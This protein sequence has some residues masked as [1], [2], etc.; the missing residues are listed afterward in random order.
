MSNTISK[1]FVTFAF[2]LLFALSTA[3]ALTVTGS[4][5]YDLCQCET[6]KQ[7]YTVCADTTGTYGVSVTGIAS[8]WIS[9]APQSLNISAGQC[10]TFYL[11]LTPECYATADLYPVDLIITG[12]EQRTVSI[13]VNVEQC[14]TFDYTIVPTTNTSKPCE[15]N[16]YNL[17]VRN[18]GKFVD[19]F[20]LLEN[21]LDDSWINYPRERFVLKAGEEL[22]SKVVVKSACSAKEGNYPFSMTLSNV[23]TNASRSINLTQI[24]TGFTPVETTFTGKQVE[25]NSCSEA[26]KEYNLYIKNVSPVA[27]EYTL[28]ITDPSILSLNKTS[29][30][31][32]SGEVAELKLIIKSA[33][34]QTLYPTL[35]ITSK[36]YAADY[37]QSFKLSIEDCQNIYLERVTTSTQSCFE[38]T[39]HL[40]RLRNNGSE[41][42]TAKISVSGIE[43]VGA[44][45]V[46]ESGKFKDFYLNF[47]SKTIGVK[48]VTV[49]A[50]TQY[51][52]SK[53][54]FNFEVMN[55]YDIQV[56]VPKIK[57]CPGA[58]IRDK[59]VF[60]NEGVRDQTININIDTAPW[61]V[62]DSAKV[63]VPA[64]EEVEVYFTANI[65]SV[66]D[67]MYFLRLISYSP[68]LDNDIVKA[69]LR[70][71]DISTNMYFELNDRDACYAYEAIYTSS[72]LDINCCQGKI[73]DL[74]ITNLG[75]FTQRIDL[76]RIAPEWV[77]FSDVN[78][79]IPQ[80][81]TKVVYIYFHPPAG[82]NGKII[83]TIELTNQIGTKKT[84][85]YDLNV[86]GGNCGLAYR[87]DLNVENTIGNTTEFTRKEVVV[88]FLVSNDSN[89][90]FAVNNI[91]VQDYNS[92]VEFEEGVFLQPGESTTAKLTVM[93]PEGVPLEDKTVSVI[94]E[95][96]V[97]TFTKSQLVKFSEAGQDLFSTGLFGQYVAPITGLLL[98]LIILVAVL[99]I[100]SK[101]RK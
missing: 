96:S 67:Q 41:T 98:L 16:T 3:S 35:K 13:S 2:F 58:V 76:K 82:T 56:V 55:C 23:L 59:L 12:P 65:P 80:G 26:G 9:I 71:Q 49:T 68:G 100:A 69:V 43:S 47:D 31:L 93:I 46:V 37:N 17:S 18:T 78:V 66:V 6:A 101:T 11:F 61:V 4:T 52:S 75:Y 54:D 10:Q 32:K 30:A 85:E 25:I 15:E 39:D 42:V 38:P 62:F 74:N 33:Q 95:T 29:I 88:D 86:F 81:E 14:H 60:K 87:V 91:Y 45:Y 21:N 90:G 79:V 48:N 51:A 64:G 24:L 5:G 83:S 77:D 99:V 92:K 44:E 57:A 84:I 36:A 20:V 22:N 63:I 7:Q 40:F 73:V 89:Y 8:K 94:V 72:H 28:A 70:E 50:Q 53:L 1:V 97:G 34:V 19:E 27:D